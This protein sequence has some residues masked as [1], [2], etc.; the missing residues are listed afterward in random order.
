MSDDFRGS[1]M[2]DGIGYWFASDVIESE[3]DTARRLDDETCEA[4]R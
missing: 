2:G 3:G 4:D 1:I